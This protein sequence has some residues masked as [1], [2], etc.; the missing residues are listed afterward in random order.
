MGGHQDLRGWSCKGS[1]SLSPNSLYLDLVGDMQRQIEKEKNRERE[2]CSDTTDINFN[3]NT[4]NYI[5][6]HKYKDA[7]E[8]TLH[9]INI[10]H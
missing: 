7:I 4:T 9:F 1:T 10:K 2:N 8:I 3:R 6:N 5:Y